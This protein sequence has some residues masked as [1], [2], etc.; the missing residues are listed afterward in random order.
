MSR[1]SEYPL[2]ALSFVSDARYPQ[3]VFEFSAELENVGMHGGRVPK[4]RANVWV[5]VIE[6]L[7]RERKLIETKDG[8][9]APIDE[10]VPKQLS[11]F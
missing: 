5:S 6:E 4:A 2:V 9:R 3:S 10:P 11:L 7:I 1:E 8:I